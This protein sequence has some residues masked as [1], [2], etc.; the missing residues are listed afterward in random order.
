MAVAPD[1]VIVAVVQFFQEVQVVVVQAMVPQTDNVQQV[2]ESL[3]KA[4]L[5]VGG[6]MAVPGPQVNYNLNQVF[7]STEVEVEAALGKKESRDSAGELTQRAAMAYRRLFKELLLNIL[8]AVAVV[9][10]MAPVIITVVPA[11]RAAK[12]AAASVQAAARKLVTMAEMVQ[13]A[14]E[15]ALFTIT[16][17]IVVAA[18]LE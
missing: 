14:A 17:I 3:A 13:A 7:V 11:T 15:P 16:A 2:M 8:V 4:I 18:A 10:F 9:V 12:V 6:I 1:Q 5:A